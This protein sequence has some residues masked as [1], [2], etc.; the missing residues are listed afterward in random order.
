VSQLPLDEIRRLQTVQHISIMLRWLGSRVVNMLD[1]STVGP[2]F[3]FAAATLSG[4]GLRQTVHIHRAF[5]HEAAK[6]VAALLRF[7]KVNASLA[8][9]NGSLP[10]GL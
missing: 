7:A 8:E 2:G 6:L 4:Y 9:N 1:S 3:K 10:P 5:L